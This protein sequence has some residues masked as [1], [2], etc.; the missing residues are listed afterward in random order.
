M[1]ENEYEAV[2]VNIIGTKNVADLALKYN[3]KKFIFVSTDKAVNSC[4]I[5][6]CTKRISEIYLQYLWNSNKSTEFI[7]TR[8][9]NVIGS[10]GSVLPKFLK[11]I[12]ENKNILVTHKDITR[13]FMTIPEASKLVILSACI[14]KGG[15]LMLFDMGEPIKIIDIANRLL[16]QL[17][18][19]D[20]KIEYVGLRPEKKCMKNYK[21]LMKKG[22][23]QNMKK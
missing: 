11:N 9:G 20:I 5:M 14:A 4:N 2:N 1:E 8:F 12:N 16:E 7:I 23:K 13:Y 3:I 15:N 22:L 6:G 10:S 18:I 21:H 17:K 19:Q